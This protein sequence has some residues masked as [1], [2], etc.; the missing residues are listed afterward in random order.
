MVFEVAPIVAAVMMHL[1][2]GITAFVRGMVL[3]A[4]AMMMPASRYSR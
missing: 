2:V 3:A 4:F 1:V